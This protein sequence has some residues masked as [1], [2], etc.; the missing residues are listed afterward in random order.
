MN[1]R[2]P[3]VLLRTAIALV[4]LFGIGGTAWL[5]DKAALNPDVLAR[6]PKWFSGAE[7]EVS[8]WLPLI[9]TFVVG[10]ACVVFVYAQAMRRL[11]AGEDLFANSYRDRQRQRLREQD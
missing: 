11:R 5:I 10:V 3:L 2:S 7:F 8:Y 6:R 1:D 4:V 9:L